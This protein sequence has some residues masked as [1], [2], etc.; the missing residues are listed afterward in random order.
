MLDSM[1]DPRGLDLDAYLARV[2][3]SGVAGP[4]LETLEALGR[5]ERLPGRLPS[6]RDGHAQLRGLA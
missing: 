6:T 5:M 3:L 1:F 4:S 2:G